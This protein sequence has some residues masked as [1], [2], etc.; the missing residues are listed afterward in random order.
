MNDSRKRRGYQSQAIV[1][2]YL[3]RHGWP[4]AEPT[5]AG[6]PG[7]D[8]TGTPAMDWEVKARADFNPTA[9]LTQLAARAK[10]GVV[11]VAVLRPNGWGEARIDDWPAVVPLSV[12]VRLLRDAGYGSHS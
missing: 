4:Y 3:K 1:A 7:S 6:R 10:E 5:G 12:L 9:A 8:I 2:N 11:G